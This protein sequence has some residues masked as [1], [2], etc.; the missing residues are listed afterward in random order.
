MKVAV[1][2]KCNLAHA[3]IPFTEWGNYYNTGK[4]WDVF[5]VDKRIISHA[6]LLLQPTGDNAK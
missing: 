6:I 1:L 5:T 4:L 3:M 2:R